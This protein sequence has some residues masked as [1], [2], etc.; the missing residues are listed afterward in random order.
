MIYNVAA[1]WYWYR[2]VRKSMTMTNRSASKETTSALPR[3][4]H[5]ELSED[6][7]D[8]VRIVFRQATASACYGGTSS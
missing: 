1:F 3:A 8:I 4:P 6:N 5:R 7:P 2:Q